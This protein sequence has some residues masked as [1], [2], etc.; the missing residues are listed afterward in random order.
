MT[1][2]PAG[3]VVG[4]MALISGRPR[5]ASVVA[6]RDSELVRL[7]SAAYDDLVGKQP[8]KVL[9]LTRA[10]VRRLERSITA[11]PSGPTARTLALVPLSPGLSVED[12][13]RGLQQA[14]E[15]QGIST[16]VFDSAL[17]DHGSA[18]FHQAETQHQLVLYQGAAP[19]EGA[20]DGWT[21]RCLRQADRV[22]LLADGSAGPPDGLPAGLPKPEAADLARSDLAEAASARQFDVVEASP[23]AVPL[24]AEREL[25][26]VIVS[27][28]LED[29]SATL[30][31]VVNG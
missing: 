6:L 24:G 30:L 14:L 19:R 21:L 15:A 23:L 16:A 1:V 29:L 28:G 3:E 20:A 4:E 8:Q 10:L 13:A 5:S 26:F 22:V 25:E 31:L 17:A 12:L 2:L 11:R 27:G 18:W 9:Q 7:P